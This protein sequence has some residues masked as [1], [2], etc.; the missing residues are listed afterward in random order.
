MALLLL[1]QGCSSQ[2]RIVTTEDPDWL[3]QYERRSAAV[4][5]LGSWSL[6]GRLAVSDES[7]GGSGRLRWQES[8][9]GVRLDFH[10]A[11]GRGAWRLQSG[12]DGAKLELA[13]G[14]QYQAPDIGQL[15]RDQLGWP[16][17]AESLAWWV[18]GMQAPGVYRERVPG[19]DGTLSVLEQ[20]G[21]TVEYGRY[22]DVDGILMPLKL[23]AR[24]QDRTVKLAVRNW[25]FGH[26]D[27]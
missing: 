1:A 2:P 3:A 25:M 10:G 8:P 15:V 20:D 22:R 17:P 9:Q 13:S 4:A 19:E 12:P 26:G 14:E 23:T 5:E 6:E 7:E 11:L 27:D 21:W 16:V 18:R 24:Q